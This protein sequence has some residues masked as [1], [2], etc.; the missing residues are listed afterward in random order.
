MTNYQ[1]LEQPCTRKKQ[2]SEVVNGKKRFAS[3]NHIFCFKSLYLN[4][5]RS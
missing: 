4:N 2:D 1:R 3:D 5:E